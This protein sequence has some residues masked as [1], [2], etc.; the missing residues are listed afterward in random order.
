MTRLLWTEAYRD[1]DVI[2]ELS[3]S[4]RPAHGHSHLARLLHQWL[5]NGFGEASQ[6]AMKCEH[7]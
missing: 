4:F 3:G 7:D 5:R 2:C 1:A 6:E